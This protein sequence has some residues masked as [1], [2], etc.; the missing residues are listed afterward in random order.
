MRAVEDLARTPII[1]IFRSAGALDSLS[2]TAP[3]AALGKHL[4]EIG[5]C[6]DV[7]RADREIMPLFATTNAARSPVIATADAELQKVFAV[8]SGRDM[9]RRKLASDSTKVEYR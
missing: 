7:D 1:E 8:L 5:R 9:Q 3:L 4:D 6:A 2:A